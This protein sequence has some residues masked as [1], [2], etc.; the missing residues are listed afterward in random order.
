MKLDD[1]VGGDV[2]VEGVLHLREVGVACF[3]VA[4]CGTEGV[5]MG[6]ACLAEVLAQGLLGHGW[7][8]LGE[9][10]RSGALQCSRD[11]V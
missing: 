7:N 3:Q 10:P 1:E 4:A 2:D 8:R 9:R 5:A 11:V 6:L